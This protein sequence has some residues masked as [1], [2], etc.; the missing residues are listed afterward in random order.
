MSVSNQSDQKW[1]SPST[2]T[3]QRAIWIALATLVAS[4]VLFVG[5][6]IWDRYIHL[7]DQSPAELNIEHIEQSVHQDPQNL[8]IRIALAE[9]YLG[10]GRYEDALTQVTQVL[11]L[12]PE[13][14]SALLIAGIAN[15][16]LNQPEAALAPLERFVAL[17][18]DQPIANVD[19][20]LEA[21]YYFLGE[22][23]IK[24]NRPAEAITVLEAALLINRTDADALYQVGLAY[25]AT[26]QPE[27]A[28]ERYHQ[29]VRFVPDFVEVYQGMIESYSTLGQS[30]QEAY[31]R[32]MEAFC[33]QDYE[34]ALPYL[35]QATKA[36]PD[37][38]PA[39]LGLGL[40]YEK[41]GQLEPALTAIQRGLELDPRDF[42]AQQALGRIQATLNP[43]N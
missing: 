9:A 29:A 17:R 14:E 32:G 38:A 42:A 20:A 33:L 26:G 35:E 2:Q 40:T 8:E 24:L 4:L 7:G 36:L 11:D 28:L 6:Y 22:S 43:Q 5:Y 25:Q 3:I 37:F 21:A 10:V 12:S 16:R 34:S 39:F 41:L 18:K 23:Y 27:K 1:R 30:D 31:A 13:H 19:S 15:V